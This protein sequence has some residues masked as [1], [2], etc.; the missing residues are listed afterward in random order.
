MKRFKTM[1]KVNANKGRSF[2]AFKWA[3]FLVLIFFPIKTYADLSFGRYRITQVGNIALLSG[4]SNPSED[5][6][7]ES[8]LSDIGIRLNVLS[9]CFQGNTVIRKVTIAEGYHSMYTD[10]FKGCTNLCEASLPQSMSYVTSGAFQDCT[11]LSDIQVGEY[12]SEIQNSAFENCTSLTMFSSPAVGTIQSRA[13]AN[14]T[15]L[16]TLIFDGGVISIKEDAFLNCTSLKTIIIKNGNLGN[17]QSGAFNGCM[18]TPE[19]Q[20]INPSDIQVRNV[21]GGIDVVGYMG[22]STSCVIPAEINGQRVIGVKKFDSDCLESV[23]VSEGI[24]TIGSYAFSRSSML[25][26]ISLPDSLLSIEDHAFAFTPL[27]SIVIP[28]GI[29][30]LKYAFEDCNMLKNVHLPNTL[31][32][33]VCT[34]VNCSAMETINLPDSLKEIGTQTFFGCSSLKNL[35]IPDSV[36]VLGDGVF[37]GCDSLESLYIGSQLSEI[38]TRA[39][40]NA[41]NLRSITVSAENPFFFMDQNSLLSKDRTRL[42]RVFPSLATGEFVVQESITQIDPSAFSGCSGLTSIRF[43]NHMEVITTG[44]F[45][46]CENVEEI[47]LPDGLLKIENSVFNLCSRLSSLYIPKTC[48]SILKQYFSNIPVVHCYYGSYAADWATRQFYEVEYLNPSFLLPSS[49]TEIEEGAFEGIEDAL[50]DLPVSL[51]TVDSSAFDDSVLLFLHDQSLVDW[52]E[53]NHYLYKIIE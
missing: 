9:R 30:T 46:N 10:A 33:L 43:L 52:A 18:E 50:I 12:L 41:G 1:E 49:L 16:E 37:S 45:Q 19:I 6:F 17:V 39:L 15:S 22:Q 11:S 31:L 26:S 47:V 23:V 35:N 34:F 7:L 20:I 21:S 24:E 44:M 42:V 32:E 4:Y 2:A 13:F 27:N 14:C 51:Q 36:T 8:D 3:L 29:T 53:N 28:D 25:E 48:T 38:G 5:L 40:S